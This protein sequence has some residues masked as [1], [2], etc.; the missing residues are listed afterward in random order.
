MSIA[1]AALI[2]ALASLVWNVVSTAYSWKFN[3]PAVKIVPTNLITG[4]PG[5]FYIDV[6]NRG[7]RAIEVKE[8]ILCWIFARWWQR[9]YSIRRGR[10]RVW[11]RRMP[12]RSGS[13][14]GSKTNEFGPGMPY[15]IEPYHAQKWAFDTAPLLRYWRKSRWSS[16][17]CLMEV[18]L[19]TGK[20]VRRKVKASYLFRYHLTQE[21]LDAAKQDEKQ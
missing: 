14:Q 17:Y 8:V 3:R 16:K 20:T 7:G 6:Q 11:L 9:N 2:I 12:T 4:R 1:V 5:W 15:T 19:A 21:M 13:L 18:Q 10:W